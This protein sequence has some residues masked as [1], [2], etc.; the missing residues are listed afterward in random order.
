MFRAST[1]EKGQVI[2]RQGILDLVK[3][4]EDGQAYALYAG[5]LV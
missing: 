5:S 4:Q 1:A 3:S 2:S